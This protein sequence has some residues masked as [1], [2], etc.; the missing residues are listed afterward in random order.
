MPRYTLRNDLSYTTSAGSERR[1]PLCR[2]DL[3]VV[4]ESRNSFGLHLGYTMVTPSP[5]IGMSFRPK[6]TQLK[7]DH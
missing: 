2:N 3:R 5:R 4:Y 1:K 7:T 6:P